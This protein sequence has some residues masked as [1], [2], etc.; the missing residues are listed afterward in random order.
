MS[1]SR[2]QFKRHHNVQDPGQPTDTS[3]LDNILGNL[4]R[5]H[6]IVAFHNQDKR[7]SPQVRLG[8]LLECNKL[9]GRRL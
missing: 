1:E 3:N 9:Y 6:G 5:E 2:L 7:V 4:W 8:A